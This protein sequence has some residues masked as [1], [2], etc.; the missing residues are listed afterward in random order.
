MKK[1]I[2]PSEISLKRLGEESLQR[3][4]FVREEGEKSPRSGATSV[5]RFPGRRVEKIKA[6][7]IA[8]I[9]RDLEARCTRDR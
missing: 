9:S 8:F 2:P 1:T 7:L 3:P 5:I 4:L 6:A